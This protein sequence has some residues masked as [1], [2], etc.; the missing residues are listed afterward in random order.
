MPPAETLHGVLA[1]Q[2][3][4]SGYGSRKDTPAASRKGWGQPPF[5][6]DNAGGAE[7]EEAGVWSWIAFF[8]RVRVRRGGGHPLE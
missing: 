4:I 5:T 2:L 7:K 1:G 6:A 3:A 8:C